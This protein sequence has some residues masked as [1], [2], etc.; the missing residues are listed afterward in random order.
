MQETE[1]NFFNSDE[2]NREL[3]KIQ[4]YTFFTDFKIRYNQIFIIVQEVCLSYKFAS[5]T[6][7]IY[8]YIQG[9]LVHRKFVAFK[10]F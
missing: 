6:G 7:T 10:R 8:L 5:L 2:G 1:P 4:F 3:P 9:I